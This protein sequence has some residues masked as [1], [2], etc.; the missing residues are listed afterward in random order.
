[1]SEE[2]PLDLMKQDPNTGNY[3]LGSIEYTPSEYSLALSINKLI[4]DMVSVKQRLIKLE[5][6]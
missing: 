4:E 1:M 3:K 5:G 6:R 2:I